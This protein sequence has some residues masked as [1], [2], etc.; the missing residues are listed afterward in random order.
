[1]NIQVLKSK[2]H[3][4]KVTEADLYYTG[5]ITI[6]EDLMDSANLIENEWVHVLNLN[7]GERIETYVIRG[8]RRSGT[9][10][11]NGPAARK[12]TVGDIAIVISYASMDFEEAK[13]FKPS[14][15]FPDDNNKI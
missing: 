9:L 2:I 5:S 6:D 3:K 8:E 12:F 14:I 4:V 15:I 1:M 7:N 11:L 10:C 13:I